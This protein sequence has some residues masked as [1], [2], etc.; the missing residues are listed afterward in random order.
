M[1]TTMNDNL[2]ALK[3][4]DPRKTCQTESKGSFPPKS[5]IGP[6]ITMKIFQVNHN[7]PF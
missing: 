5:N 6:R 7:L 4:N 2:F 3:M 1:T